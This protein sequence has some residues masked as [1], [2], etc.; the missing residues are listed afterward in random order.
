MKEFI[1]ILGLAFIN[2]VISVGGGAIVLF[3]NERTKKLMRYLIPLLAGVLLAT[4]LLDIL[5][6]LIP[7]IYTVALVWFVVA[8]SAVFLFELWLKKHESKNDKGAKSVIYSLG[9]T[10]II[11]NLIFGG[12]IAVFAS[13]Y[14]HGL[15]IAIFLA[16]SDI[17]HEIGVFGKLIHSGLTRK[18]ALMLNIL[19]TIPTIIGAGIGYYLKEDI[20]NIVPIFMAILAGWFLYIS[21]HDLFADM[22]KQ[23]DE[24]NFGWQ[25]FMFIAGILLVA[26]VLR[27]FNCILFG[28]HALYTT[29]M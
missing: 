1:T 19:W 13:Y 24:V 23:N 11:H 26:W 16:I 18:K 7:F 9:V 6:D 5:P 17:P 20:Y 10:S 25:A 22:E 28:Y 14:A 2:G 27:R 4:A 12:L 21:M 3:H 29:Y 8:I 15:R